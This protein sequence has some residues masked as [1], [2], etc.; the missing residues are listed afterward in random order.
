M[1]LEGEV[2]DFGCLPA[3]VLEVDLVVSSFPNLAKGV[4]VLVVISQFL[5]NQS[6][7]FVYLH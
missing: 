7:V 2:S 6:V 1:S 4:R 5:H 3:L